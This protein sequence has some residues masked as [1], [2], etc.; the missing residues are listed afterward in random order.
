VTFSSLPSKKKSVRFQ[1]YC[2]IGV[3]AQIVLQFHEMRNENPHIFFHRWVN[4]LWYGLMGWEQIWKKSCSGFRDM[5]SLYVDGQRVV[6]PGDCEGVVFCNILSYGGGS[7]LWVAEVSL[8]GSNKDIMRVDCKIRRYLPPYRRKVL[9]WLQKKRIST[10]KANFSMMT[11]TAS[12]I[13]RITGDM[14]SI[15]RAPA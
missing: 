10:C 12:V 15:G 8:D 7:R 13:Q 11:V 14:D 9:L 6:I 5:V 4:K 1:N 3:D 2:G